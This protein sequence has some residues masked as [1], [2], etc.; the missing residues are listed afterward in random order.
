MESDEEED[1]KQAIVRAKQRMDKLF[2]W[3]QDYEGGNAKK[4]SHIV[5]HQ[6]SAV[7]YDIQRAKSDLKKTEIEKQKSHLK[8]PK[9]SKLAS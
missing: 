1:H 8:E 3:F 2:H 6:N 5:H 4:S 7:D 9:A